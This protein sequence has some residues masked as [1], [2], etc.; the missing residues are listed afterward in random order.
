MLGFLGIVVLY[1]RH[2]LR[3]V[4]KDGA[5]R[6]DDCMMVPDKATGAVMV[7]AGLLWATFMSPPVS[8]FPEGWPS[9]CRPRNAGTSYSAPGQCR[10][11]TIYEYYG[12]NHYLHFEGNKLTSWQD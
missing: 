1:A 2:V 5:L 7:V 11:G 8:A 6:L 10:V 3:R 9:W 12:A 4:S